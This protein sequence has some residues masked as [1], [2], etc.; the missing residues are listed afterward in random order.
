[1]ELEKFPIFWDNLRKAALC[2]AGQETE[3]FHNVVTPTTPEAD[4]K[5]YKAD[6]AVFDEIF[7]GVRVLRER[8]P[9]MKLTHGTKDDWARVARMSKQIWGSY[10]VDAPEDQ[11]ITDPDRKPLA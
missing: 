11:Y 3:V 2:R 8:T 9:E 10:P 6:V 5:D 1:M 4:G 7:T